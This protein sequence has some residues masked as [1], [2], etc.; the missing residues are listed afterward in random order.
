MIRR[1]PATPPAPASDASAAL[2]RTLTITVFLLWLGSTSIIPMLPV[3]ILSLI[4][5]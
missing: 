3:Y 1:G 4:H 2:I 5:I